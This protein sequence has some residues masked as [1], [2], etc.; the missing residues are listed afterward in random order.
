MAWFFCRVKVL[1]CGLACRS[2]VICGTN[3]SFSTCQFFLLFFFFLFINICLSSMICDNAT[4]NLTNCQE[5]WLRSI[6]AS[7]MTWIPLS[8][9]VCLHLQVIQYFFN[10]RNTQFLALFQSQKRK[11][12]DG[13]KAFQYGSHCF[14][15]FF[16]RLRLGARTGLLYRSLIRE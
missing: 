10:S 4:N 3:F 6:I 8:M 11:T 12:S 14:K 2:L 13:S 7:Q 16:F 15:T 9:L 5:S 1:L